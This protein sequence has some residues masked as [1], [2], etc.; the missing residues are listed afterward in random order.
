MTLQTDGTGWI[1]FG[2]MAKFP[3]FDEESRRPRLLA[4]LNQVPGISLPE[5]RIDLY[6]TFKIAALRN[7][8]ALRRFLAIFA[9]AF[10]E[11]RAT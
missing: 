5:D 11:V 6:P 2:S 7:P 9:D 1:S 10:R 8:E 3:P 4:E